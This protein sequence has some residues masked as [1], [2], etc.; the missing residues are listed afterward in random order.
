[1]FLIIWFCIGIC[2]TLFYVGIMELYHRRWRQVP[3]V[4]VITAAPTTTVSIIIPARNE[5]Q[6]IGHLLRDIRQQHY[7]AEL[8]EV[9][10]MDDH[11]EDDTY[12]IAAAAGVRVYKLQELLPN[13]PVSEV[14]KKRAIELAVQRATGKLIVTTD[15]DCR[16]PAGW[17][18]HIAE[19]YES[20]GAKLLAGPVLLCAD[21][22]LFE[23]FQVLDFCGMQAIT[24]ASLH[25]G[26]NNMANGANLAYERDA[27]LAVDGYNGIDS[28]ASGDDMLLVYKIAQRYPGTVHYLKARGATV[29]TE[30]MHTLPEFLQQ[31]FRWTSKTGQYQDKRMTIILGLIYLFT[32][33]LLLNLSYAINSGD[34]SVW[35]LFLVQLLAKA[36]IDFIFLRSA[37]VFFG[38]RDLMR[39]FITSELLHI[40]YIVFVGTLGNIMPYTWKGRKLR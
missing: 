28:K 21:E 20:R 30:V 29:R 27:F 16:V 31:R 33:S 9:I 2:L 19:I 8:I 3:E 15:A 5:A 32:L 40:W 23:Q 17:I 35:A 37:V 24:A 39:S 18:R 13:P 22:T 38:R 36:G 12:A 11:S 14:F 7:P 25:S 4:D 10:V 34:A 6:H 1:M 26:L